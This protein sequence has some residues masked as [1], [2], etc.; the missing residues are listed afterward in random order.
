MDPAHGSFDMQGMRADLRI[1]TAYIQVGVSSVG[2]LFPK[3]FETLLL[4]CRMYFSRN[5]SNALAFVRAV[6]GSGVCGRTSVGHFVLFKWPPKGV[7]G[8]HKGRGFTGLS[9]LLTRSKLLI[10]LFC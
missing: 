4:G 7:G 6:V 3:N 2:I 1:A 9:A 5:F 10:G 8:L